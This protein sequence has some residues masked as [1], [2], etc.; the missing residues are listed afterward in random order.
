MGRGLV[1]A[2]SINLIVPWIPG[3]DRIS[4]NRMRRSEGEILPNDPSNHNSSVIRV[5]YRP[6]MI[7][8]NHPILLPK[9]INVDKP[10]NRAPPVRL[11]AILRHVGA[12][13][14]ATAY[15]PI[16]VQHPQPLNLYQTTCILIPFIERRYPYSPL[17]IE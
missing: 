16:P 5:L 13:S 15:L 10:Y 6:S 11:P 7:G 4:L 17:D 12:P 3:I 2:L 1:R 9:I 14:L 8:T